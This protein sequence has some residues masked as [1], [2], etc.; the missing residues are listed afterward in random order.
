[1]PTKL[2]AGQS[3]LPILC[4]GLNY[5]SF[6][7]LQP[8]TNDCSYSNSQAIQKQ[9]GCGL[10]I[11]KRGEG[12][13]VSQQPS[14]EDEARSLAPEAW[15]HLIHPLPLPLQTQSSKTLPQWVL[16]SPPP[17]RSSHHPPRS[18]ERAG[19]PGRWAGGPLLWSSSFSS[20]PARAEPAPN[21]SPGP[22]A[23]PRSPTSFV[24]VSASLILCP[25]DWAPG[26]PDTSTP[27]RSVGEIHI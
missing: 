16:L 21:P 7:H 2:R 24:L 4:A 27:V 22:Q 18:S 17:C 23:P 3:E 9:V 10:P 11:H 15:S 19:L 6:W 25:L 14:S 8:F 26:C 13:T 5:S 12:T 20:R 1:M